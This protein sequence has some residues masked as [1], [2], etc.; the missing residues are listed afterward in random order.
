MNDTAIMTLLGFVVVAITVITPLMK[1]NSSIVQLRA[2]IDNLA[3]KFDDLKDR[4]DAHE[5][6]IGALETIAGVHGVRLDA[7]E[8]RPARKGE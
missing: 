1:L 3:D 2:S 8:G 7:L 5:Q 6:Q 4:V